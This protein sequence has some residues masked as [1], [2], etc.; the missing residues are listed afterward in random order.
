M[1]CPAKRHETALTINTGT[2]ADQDTCYSRHAASRIHR[3]QQQLV[4][5][6]CASFNN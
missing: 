4:T 2:T 5:G 3:H 1:T 6:T